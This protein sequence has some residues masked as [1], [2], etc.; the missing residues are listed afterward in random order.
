[1]AVPLYRK[2]CN[3][4]RLLSWSNETMSGAW[5]FDDF[6]FDED[7]TGNVIVFFGFRKTPSGFG[8]RYWHSTRAVKIHGCQEL[9]N[10]GELMD[11]PEGFINEWIMVI[12]DVFAANADRIFGFV[13]DNKHLN[14]I[15]MVHFSIDAQEKWHAEQIAHANRHLNGDVV[16][17]DD[18]QW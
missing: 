5:L 16:L 13:A 18:E 7:L 14:E 10:K 6:R 11:P 12:E 2:A 8:G 17:G 3:Y 9:G 4:G 15:D 1:M